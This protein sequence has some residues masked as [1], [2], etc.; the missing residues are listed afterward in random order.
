M[1]N[2]TLLNI[3]GVL[4]QPLFC[5]QFHFYSFFL[6]LEEE[7][8]ILAFGLKSIRE[9]VGALLLL[10]AFSGLRVKRAMHRDTGAELENTNPVSTS[11]I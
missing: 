6:S 2:P 7:S 3:R 9:T 10:S 4:I 8:K 11:A 5:S 1:L